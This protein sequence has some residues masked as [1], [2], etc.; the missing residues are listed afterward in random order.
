MGAFYLFQGWFIEKIWP[1]PTFRPLFNAG[2][3]LIIG[4]LIYVTQRTTGYL[5][6]KLGFIKIELHDTGTAD[7]RYVLLQMI[8]PA[9]ILT[10]G[11]SLGPE[12]TLVSS[13]V[14]YGVWILDK[15][16]YLDAHWHDGWWA[17]IK[18]MSLPHRYLL[19]RGKARRS[20]SWW[21]PRT[22]SYLAIG[23]VSFY[24]TC[25]LGG[26]RSVIV[27]LGHSNWQLN[28][29]KWLLPLVIFGLIVGRCWLWLMVLLRNIVLDRIT[30][31]IGLIALGGIAIYLATLFAPAINFSGMINFHL[32]ATSWQH[33]SI[34]F[35][36]LQSLLKL[37]LLTICL[38]TGWLG[39]EIFPVLF[40]ATAQ[41]IA[42]SQLLPQIDPIFLIGIFAIS[43]G[44]VILES[45]LIAGGVMSIMFLPP[46]LLSVSL[47]LTAGLFLIRR[48]LAPHMSWL[49]LLLP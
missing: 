20:E 44:T 39:G 33:Q 28:D 38:N 43:M 22:I 6:K 25:K 9:F 10:S 13:T 49:K 27:Y 7:Y 2:W 30:R 8:I 17:T 18:A 5:P 12:A 42:L 40:C 36:L 41:G 24:L 1:G 29:L 16:R 26:E 4:T 31:D 45:P 48:Y 35:L 19:A 15:C 37:A 14:L 32:L 11:T 23:I 34:A 21:S 46:S 47:G 3:L